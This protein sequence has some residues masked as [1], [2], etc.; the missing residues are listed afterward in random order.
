M[1]SGN[2][3]TEIVQSP[4]YTIFF[5]RVFGTDGLFKIFSHVAVGIL[6]TSKLILSFPALLSGAVFK[7]A[8]KNVSSNAI[9]QGAKSLEQRLALMHNAVDLLGFSSL[10]YD[11]TPIARTP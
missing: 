7:I 11:Y 10:V 9:F 4:N 1:L 3:K 2:P 8:E 6:D 5:N